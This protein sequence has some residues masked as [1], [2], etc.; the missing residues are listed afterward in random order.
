[1]VCLERDIEQLTEE[2]RR[3]IEEATDLA[4]L[5]AIRIQYLGRRG[6]LTVLLRS[7]GQQPP[8]VRPRLGRV[9]NEAKQLLQRLLADKRQML[10]KSAK[11]PTE[12]YDVT[13]PGI[14]PLV[15]RRHPL[16]LVRR[17]M[18][19]IFIGLGFEVVEGREVETDFYN[20]VAL[21]IPKDH[22]ARDM[23][24][25]FYLSEEILLRTQTS[26]VQVRVMRERAPQ[27]PLRIVAPG[28]VYRRGDDDATH[29]PVFHQMELLAVDV[30]LSMA[31][32]KGVLLDFARKMFGPDR[33]IRLRPSY[34]PFTEPSA[35][36]DVSCFC[37]GEGCRLC[38]G[39][40]WLEILGAGMVH[41][42]VLR[43]GGYDP[44]YVSGFAAG[45]GIERVAMLKYGVDDIRHFYRNDL[46][47]LA[48]FEDMGGGWM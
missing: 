4:Q 45:L 36:V 25:S 24:S 34:F 42:V 30:G 5:D 44:E 35:E 9:A 40:G 21:N 26:P 31:H 18:E 41:P 47:F 12:A 23:Q 11:V 37:D 22:P 6:K 33:K 19:E 43:N 46:S 16:S 38:D 1:V 14:S 3:L 2:A 8:E 20:F 27:V 28:R 29:S 48:C 10:V 39:T 7:L 13:L 15:G 32:M 17:Q